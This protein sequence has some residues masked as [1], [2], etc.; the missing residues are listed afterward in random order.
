MHAIVL[1][2]IL[3]TEDNNTQ[4]YSYHHNDIKQQLVF[5]VFFIFGPEGIILFVF[6]HIFCK[7]RF[8]SWVTCFS[9]PHAKRTCIV[10]LKM[11]AET[12][13]LWHN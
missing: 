8:L 13:Y 3:L 2:M 12:S 6:S 9:N 11:G 7:V 5:G 10:V 1:P 4:H